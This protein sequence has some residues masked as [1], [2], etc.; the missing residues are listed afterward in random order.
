MAS[1]ITANDI[2]YAKAI[3]LGWYRRSGFYGIEREEVESIA[4][5]ALCE[6]ARD[7]RPDGGSQLRTFAHLRILGAVKNAIRALT[8]A[9]RSHISVPITEAFAVA[10]PL[11]SPEQ[12]AIAKELVGDVRRLPARKAE[13]LLS[14]LDGEPGIELAA[15]RGIT[16]QAVWQ[17]ARDAREEFAHRRRRTDRE[18]A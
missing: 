1:P 18:V 15:R 8:G 7:W 6:A 3:A 17:M 14:I 4:T 10:S 11:P 13:A 5:L 9:K 12:I 2:Q 16:S